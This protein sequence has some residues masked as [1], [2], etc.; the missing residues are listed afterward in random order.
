M[1]FFSAVH[2]SLEIKKS[3]VS[4]FKLFLP[5]KYSIKY[6][7]V[8]FIHVLQVTVFFF[9][10]AC[11]CTGGDGSVVKHLPSKPE[12]GSLDLQKPM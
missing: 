11:Y 4:G 9:S 7:S 3:H 12:V 2:N 8:T 5:M 6:C 1:P 10:I